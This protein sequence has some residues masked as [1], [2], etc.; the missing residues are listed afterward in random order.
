MALTLEFHCRK[1]SGR[2]TYGQTFTAGRSMWKLSRS[3]ID[4]SALHR[5]HP[6]RRAAADRVVADLLA[7]RRVGLGVPAPAIVEEPRARILIAVVARAHGHRDD[8]REG[9]AEPT[10]LVA[11]ECAGAAPRVDARLVEH[12]VRDP[13]ADAGGERLV[14]QQRLHRRRARG[15]QRLEGGERRQP[16]PRVEAE[17]ADGRLGG[18][19]QAQPRAAQAARVGERQLAAVVEFPCMHF[20]MTGGFHTPGRGTWR[21]VAHGKKGPGLDWPPRFVK[22]ILRFDDG[23]EL[24]F[25]D[26][27]R[28]GRAR[29]RVDPAAEPPISLLGF[30]AWRG[31]P[32]LGS[33]KALVTA[34]SSPMKALLLDQSFAAGVGNWIA[35]EVL[36][37]ARI[38]PRRRAGTLTSDE[39]R[40]LRTA[41][42][43]VIAVSV[44]ARND[45][46]Q[47]P[48]TWLFHDRWGR[49][50]KAYTARGEKIRHDTVGG[51]TT[52][53][54]PSVQR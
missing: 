44:R 14:E 35:D 33:F 22:L 2:M 53:W 32:A 7:A 46:D 15:D 49:N 34:R 39:I 3:R 5:R 29:L 30:D 9:G 38:D 1:Y 20:G 13:V 27:R 8:A 40:R 28:L 16:A 31:L 10:D 19:I 47:Y 17:Q 42:A 36:Y 6:G 48:R 23:G 25:A 52:A 21:L 12:L 51:R 50:P 41:L 43:R 45:S 24:A 54:V 18:G 26:A 4:A 11:R 37:Q